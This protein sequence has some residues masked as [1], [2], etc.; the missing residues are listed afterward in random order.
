M[1]TSTMSACLCDCL[2]AST[3]RCSKGTVKMCEI[4][5]LTVCLRVCLC[6]ST[7][8]CSKGTIEMR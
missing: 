8:R 6:V 4:E 5:V 1:F 3:Y 7:Y 2:C